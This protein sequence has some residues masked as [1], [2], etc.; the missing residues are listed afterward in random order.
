MLIHVQ[1][2]VMIKYC[3]TLLNHIS[4]IMGKYVT[5]K[6]LEHIIQEFNKALFNLDVAIEVICEHYC[7]VDKAEFTKFISDC[8]KARIAK[9]NNKTISENKE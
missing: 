7:M 4:D 6:E 9:E 3:K 5:Q 2:H 8:A 1:I